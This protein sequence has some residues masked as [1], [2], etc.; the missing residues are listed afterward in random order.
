MSVLP[1][2]AE[3]SPG[4]S[5][6]AAARGHP[7]TQF[8]PQLAGPELADPEAPRAPRPPPQ[9]QTGRP[10][11]P[12]V[13]ASLITPRR[14]PPSL[15][16][17]EGAGTALPPP[18]GAVPALAP[19]SHLH[20][21]GAAAGRGSTLARPPLQR[22][23]RRARLRAGKRGTEPGADAHLR[24]TP[25]P[26]RPAASADPGRLAPDPAGAVAPPQA[27]ASL[28]PPRG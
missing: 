16:P 11:L 23:N 4:F 7:G 1:L 28:S 20:L 15:H 13:P 25:T 14:A 9:P 6:S 3:L 21:R 22:P 27:G 26:R 5:S 24:A 17:G 12:H 10:L 8:Q 18:A 19:T 2:D